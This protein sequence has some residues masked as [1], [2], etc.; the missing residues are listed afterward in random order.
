ML[1]NWAKLNQ[2]LN[3]DKQSTG[4]LTKLNNDL[5]NALKALNLDPSEDPLANWTKLNQKFNEDKQSTGELTK[6]NNELKNT[7]KDLNL[8]PTEDPLAN[9]TKLIRNSLTIN[10]LTKSLPILTTN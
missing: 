4:E 7:L 5:K 6:L 3:D 8:E 9:W 1:A 2:K 10:R